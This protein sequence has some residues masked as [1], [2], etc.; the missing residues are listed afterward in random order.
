MDTSNLKSTLITL[1]FD[2]MRR[3]ELIALYE[4]LCDQFKSIDAKISVSYTHLDV[5]KRQVTP[6]DT[7]N[8]IFKRMSPPMTYFIFRLT[9]KDSPNSICIFV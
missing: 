6:I 5:Y 1:A 7:S 9:T 3:I 2:R 8:F 4:N